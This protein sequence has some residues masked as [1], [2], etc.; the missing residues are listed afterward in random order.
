MTDLLLRPLIIF[1]CDGVLVDS[2]T[3]AAKVFSQQLALEGISYSTMECLHTFKG[4][5]LD[6][7]MS[8]MEKDFGWI[9]SPSFLSALDRATAAAFEG[10]LQ[11]V[12]G[13]EAVIQ[14]LRFHNLSYCLA[15]NGGY[16]KIQRSLKIT[17]LQKYFDSN[18]YSAESVEN[19]KPAPDLFEYAVKDMRHTGSAVVVEDSLS[20]V[21]A[22]LA[23]NMQV[24]LFDNENKETEV[25]TG[26]AA[27]YPEGEPY[28]GCENAV[29][30]KKGAK[31]PCSGVKSFSSMTQL[32][33]L[34]SKYV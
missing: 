27:Q 18:I 25:D 1:D 31:L 9:V 33:C 13:V 16:S 34:L 17:G 4:H 19:G 24:L 14:W 7:C 21:Q 6:A 5:T 10:E 30:I 11:A 32:T 26:S 12:A 15:S 23:A 8:K 20:G 29:T 22:A 28:A 2:E 3:L